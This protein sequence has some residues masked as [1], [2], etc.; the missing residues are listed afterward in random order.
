VLADQLGTGVFNAFKQ[1]Q[2]YVDANGPFT[3]KLTETQ[4]NFLKGL[5]PTFDAVHTSLTDAQ[6]KNGL[7]QKR[8]DTAHTDLKNQADTLSTMVGGIT[9]VDMAEAVTRLESAK[10]A[11]QA[12]AQ[13]FASL[14]NSSLLNVL[15]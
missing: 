11:V 14:Q 4:S 9:D 6:A 5:L 2:A 12:S 13:V 3:G 1:V 7:N 8:F 10:L 15:K